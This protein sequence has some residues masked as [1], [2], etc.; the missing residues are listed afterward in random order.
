[1]IE[2]KFPDGA[3]REYPLA[4]T[5]RQVAEGLSKS[6][7]KK[8]ALIRLDGEMLDLDRPLEH[9]GAIEILTRD[10]PDVLF[11]IRHDASHVMAEAVQ[12]LFPGT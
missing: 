9:G 11:T 8:A 5:G 7:A 12:S 2:L 4:T 1:M 3:Q 10:H 6:L